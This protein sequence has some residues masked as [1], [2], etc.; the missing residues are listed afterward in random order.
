MPTGGGLQLGQ[1]YHQQQQQQQQQQ[2]NNGNGYISPQYGWYISM[3]PPTPPQ[4]HEASTSKRKKDRQ[5]QQQQQQPQPQPQNYQQNQILQQ[6]QLNGKVHQQQILPLTHNDGKPIIMT[7]A[8]TQGMGQ[9]PAVPT[10]P[11]FT[12]NLKG[13]PNN[14]SGWPS[15]PL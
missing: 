5:Q 13:V 10:R 15:V 9:P 7:T 11:V 8:A 6:Q 3:T 12:R 14:T 1:Q 4:Y 2:P